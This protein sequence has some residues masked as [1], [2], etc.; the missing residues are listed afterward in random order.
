VG[1][2]LAAKRPLVGR[3]GERTGLTTAGYAHPAG[4]MA[5]PQRC[6][7]DH[8]ASGTDPFAAGL[9]TALSS[10]LASSHQFDQA[11]P[12]LRLYH[13]RM[14]IEE[15][16][17]DLKDNGFDLERSALEHFLRL[18]RLTLAVALL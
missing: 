12:I 15:T 9:A 16:Y 18:S 10:P 14:W 11:A 3:Y 13:R 2:R 8:D 5:F 17:G 4:P 6:S 1:L 7:L